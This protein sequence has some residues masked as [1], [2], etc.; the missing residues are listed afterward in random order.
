[1]K[2]I[3]QNYL[4]SFV[5]AAFVLASCGGV[6][7]MVD[8]ANTVTYDVQPSPLETHAGEV[9]VT[10]KTVF[11][12]KYFNK[13]AIVVA[14]PMLKYEGGQTEFG[15]TT[16]QGEKVDANN[17]VIP[18][19]GGNYT[20][21]GKIPY[22]EAMLSS[23]LVVEMSA[24]IGDKDP[25]VIPGIKIADGV[26][27]TSTLV[28]ITPKS[29]LVGDKFERV[30]PEN[31][32]A[33]IKYVINKSEVR[34][35]ELKKDEIK[36]FQDKLAAAKA[37]ER[38]EFKSASISAY[39][40][41]DGAYDLNEKLAE[42]RKESANLYFTRTLKKNEIEALQNADFLKLMSTA[43]D[44]DGF[45]ALMEKSD[46]QDKDLIL[47]VLSMY[48]D[49]AVR[50][51]EIKNIAEAFEEIKEQV[52]PE[53]R[54]SKMNVTVDVVGYSDEELQALAKNNPDTLK[55]EEILYSA[56]L[57]DNLGDKIAVY[58][59]AAKNFP[60]CFRAINNVG[61]VAMEMGNVAEAK[62]AFEQA[63]SLMDND[64]VK[65]NLGAVALLE[66][67]VAGAETLFNSAMGAGDVVSYNLGIVKI[68][69]GDYAAAVN[70]FGNKASYNAALAQ[71]LNNNSEKSLSTL[72]E[73]GDSD[74]A[75]VYYLK[76][77]AGARA[78]KEDVVL[79]NLR[80]ATGKDSALKA[81]ALKD[82][83]FAKFAASE[84]FGGIVK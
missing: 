59:V 69:Q 70:Y 43:E 20:F 15:S 79:S 26:I 33:D 8:T 50:E 65:N 84:A 80:T 52:L 81:H 64:V 22:D 49:P 44:W 28:E 77:V 63:K 25:V 45:K 71:L 66:G 23:D 12:E 54:R 48:S 53:L 9:E 57:F 67:D 75:M 56:T 32:E 41:P 38:K 76:A 78:G 42:K 51:K 7:K 6:N 5:I 82:L 40:S 19:A 74:D 37:A 47:R 10:I 11:P 3:K 36:S 73:L 16:L 72:G 61:Y 18:V 2:R 17:K 55:L 13:K 1:M 14:T 4:S 83:E 24:S 27:A 35:S 58:K 21:T 68:I 31:Y 29:I 30:I 39:A 34:N 46:I 62:A 60:K